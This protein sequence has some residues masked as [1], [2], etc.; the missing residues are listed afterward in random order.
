V[1]RPAG[2][3]RV[4]PLKLA[5]RL[6]PETPL[7]WACAAGQQSEEL[8][9]KLEAEILAA[10]PDFLTR[11]DHA[12]QMDRRIGAKDTTAMRAAARVGASCVAVAG[13]AGSERKP[14]GLQRCRPTK[15]L[16]EDHSFQSMQIPSMRIE[17]QVQLWRSAWLRIPTGIHP[18]GRSETTIRATRSP[19][20]WTLR[21]GR[22]EIIQMSTGAMFS[23]PRMGT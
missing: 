19:T 3:A 22:S 8:S 16:I 12:A 15:A 5:A 20:L 13:K 11:A 10:F 4:G 17:Q 14:S 2:W 9:P 1:A 6:A 7:I 23:L 21:R 18:P